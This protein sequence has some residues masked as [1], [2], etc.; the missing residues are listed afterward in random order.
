MASR[1]LYL[2]VPKRANDR[3]CRCPLTSRFFDWRSR[4]IFV[5]ALV[6]GK[7]NSEALLCVCNPLEVDQGDLEFTIA[8]TTDPGSRDCSEP[9][10]HPK[11][12]LMH[13]QQFPTGRAPDVSF[14][15]QTPHL[16]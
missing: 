2:A 16:Q 13:E 10:D 5:L 12:G 9:F 3:L 6:F 15:A 4:G 14:I 11:I 7:L 8:N 1:E